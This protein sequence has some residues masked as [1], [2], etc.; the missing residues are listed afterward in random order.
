MQ[1]MAAAMT[2]GATATGTRSYIAAKQ[3]AWVT[4]TRLKRIT[5]ALIAV[6]LLSS[7]L[8]IS[9]SGSPAGSATPQ[10]QTHGR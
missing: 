5:L 10:A 9:G 1:C 2:A 6:A 4:P 7:S 3:F 8:I